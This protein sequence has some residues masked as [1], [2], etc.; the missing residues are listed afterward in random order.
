MKTIKELLEIAKKKPDTKR[1]EKAVSIG[2]VIEKMAEDERLVYGWANIT[3]EN[4]QTVVD[5][6]GD[7][8]GTK[9]L[10][11]AAHDFMKQS[12]VGKAMHSGRPVAEVVESVIFTPELQKQLGIDL[13]KTGWFIGVQVYDAEVW[14]RV[15]QG[16]LRAFSIGGMCSYG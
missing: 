1:A 3:E 2:F 4:G 12:R 16:E 9:E 13:K 6:H 7:T 15:K 11:A 10:V 5:A 14:K 8:I